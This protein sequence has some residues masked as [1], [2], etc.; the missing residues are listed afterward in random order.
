MTHSGL[1]EIQNRTRTIL[2]N[3]LSGTES[4][5]LLDFPS[6]QNAGDSLIY[7]GQVN[8]LNQLGIEI[9]YLAD[10]FRYDKRD[11]DQIAPGCPILLQGGGNFG[12]RWPI[13][14]EFRQK[15]VLENPS[16]RIIQLPQSID[17]ADPQLR[18]NS[19]IAFREHKDLTLM[20]RESRSVKEG[21]RLYGST[22]QVVFCPDMAFGVGKLYR[23]HR[24]EVDVVMLLRQDSE[25]RHIDVST[26]GGPSE[27]R[28]D[29]GLRGLESL[30]WRIARLPAQLSR[31]A[32]F[33]R[34]LLYP[35]VA[36]GYQAQCA[37]NIF[38]ARKM[39]ER[40]RVLVTDR[41]HATVLGALIGMPVIALDNANGK[42]SSIY[43]EYLHKFDNV[44]FAANPDDAEKRLHLEL[45]KLAN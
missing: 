39:I 4:V 28:A 36:R 21:T 35:V 19:Q 1:T 24:P 7:A 31:H 23:V 32:G 3:L 44:Y 2:S 38:A 40:G 11:L 27:Y 6:H 43:S 25:S 17:F 8:Y 30:G 45:D 18:E 26:Q 34:P 29:W 15:V 42:I 33:L 13:F 22:A 9:R 14:Q 5:A 41:L 12:D 20:F 10:I 37:L 16:R